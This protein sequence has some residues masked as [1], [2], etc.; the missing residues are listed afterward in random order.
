MKVE[1]E[2]MDEFMQQ[3]ERLGDDVDKHTDEALINAG[4]LLQKEVK[5]RVPVD[6]GKLRDNIMLSEVKD[7]TIDVYVDQQG[8]AYYG[9][10]L[11]EGTSKMRARP[12]MYPA[13]HNSQFRIRREIVETLRIRLGLIP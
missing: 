6:T 12:F 4:K 10:F 7:K 3:L 1:F 8:P 2:G 13:F 11:E 5:K 9:V